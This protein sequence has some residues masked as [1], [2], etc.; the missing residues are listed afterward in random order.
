MREAV[1]W[2]GYVVGEGG[3]VLSAAQCPTH[4]KAHGQQNLPRA[5]CKKAVLG[6]LA[7]SPASGTHRDRYLIMHCSLFQASESNR[8][9]PPHSCLLEGSARLSGR[10]GV[11]SCHIHARDDGALSEN[12]TTWFRQSFSAPRG[13]QTSLSEQQSSLSPRAILK[14]VQRLFSFWGRTSTPTV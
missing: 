8:R 4:C 1:L 14:K 13:R 3:C 5:M 7:C 10:D 9:E 2:G 6:D 11:L 12:G